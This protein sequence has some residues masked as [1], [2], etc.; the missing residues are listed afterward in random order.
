MN[1]SQIQ[2]TVSM[3]AF[4][5]AVDMHSHLIKLLPSPPEA[6]NAPVQKV[7]MADVTGKGGVIDVMG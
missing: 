1:T 2:N 3:Y 7:N 4:K 6:L 5:K